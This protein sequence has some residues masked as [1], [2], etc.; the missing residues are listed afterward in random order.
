MNYKDKIIKVNFKKKM[1]TIP[2]E[3]TEKQK[4]DLALIELV[5]NIRPYKYEQIFTYNS[6]RKFITKHKDYIDKNIIIEKYINDKSYVCDIYQNFYGVIYK[7]E[8]DGIWNNTYYIKNEMLDL[9]PREAEDIYYA[10]TLCNSKNNL[11]IY[12]VLDRLSLFGVQITESTYYYVEKLVDKIN[13]KIPIG[14]Y[15]SSLEKSTPMYS[16]F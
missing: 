7:G 10:V 12:E 8:N 11:T 2:H 6:A 9:D 4:Y 5:Y 14:E 16:P 1:N 15:L 13:H 3:I